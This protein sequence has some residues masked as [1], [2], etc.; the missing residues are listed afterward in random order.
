MYEYEQILV[1]VTDVAFALN[2]WSTSGWRLVQLIDHP[3]GWG[4]NEHEVTLILE[5]P[6]RDHSNAVALR[7]A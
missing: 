1:G 2:N 7:A 3:K 6:V 4:D 5:R